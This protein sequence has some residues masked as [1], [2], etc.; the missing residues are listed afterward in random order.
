M[1]W[2]NVKEHYR[3]VH[4]VSVTDQGICIGSP[5]IHNIIVIGRDGE[6]VKREKSHAN[7]ELVRYQAEMDAD[8]EKL[9]ELVR[10]LDTFTKD[11]TVY[12]YDRGDIIER[13]CEELGWPNVTHGGEMMYENTFSADKAT[14]VKWAKKNAQCGIESRQRRVEEIRKE[15]ADMERYLAESQADL[16]KLE[17]EHP[18]S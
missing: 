6:I 17:A 18:T 5:Y 1:G 2:K 13:H 7:A 10:S 15:L 11:I 16:A 3:I 9:R 12:T 14:V 8:P 4:M